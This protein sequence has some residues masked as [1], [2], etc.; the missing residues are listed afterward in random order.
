MLAEGATISSWGSGRLR[1]YVDDGG[2][3]T[4]E[5]LASTLATLVRSGWIAPTAA[6]DTDRGRWTEYGISAAGRAVSQ[7]AEE[8]ELGKEAGGADV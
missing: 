3:T 1:A 8:E 5:I 4:R 2:D 7:S 6:R